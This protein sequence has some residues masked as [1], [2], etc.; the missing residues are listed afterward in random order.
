MFKKSFDLIQ[1][2]P[3]IQ[4]KPTQSI[5][6]TELKPTL[7]KFLAKKLNKKIDEFIKNYPFRI[8]IK[9]SNLKTQNIP[10]NM[11][12]FGNMG[13]NQKKF[14][15]SNVKI[16]FFSYNEN[17]LNLIDR[18]IAEFFLL[19]NFGAR[20]SKGFGSFTVK[21]KPIKFNKKVYS[22][23]VENWIEEVGYFYKLL[24]SGINEY[25]NKKHLLYAKPLIFEFAC[26]NN[27]SWEK[28]EIKKEFIKLGILKKENGLECGT[29]H[30]IIKDL[31]GLSTNEMWRSYKFKEHNIKIIKDDG[32]NK[33]DINKIE[34]YPSP[35]LFKP[36]KVGDKMKIYFFKRDIESLNSNFYFKI[37]EEY[38]EGRNKVSKILKTFRLNTAHLDIDDFLD[39]VSKIDNFAFKYKANDKRAN[40]INT[41]IKNIFNTLKVENV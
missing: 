11:L 28:R 3:I 23:E 36:I 30:K 37:L 26:N 18:Y 6:E 7:N 10:Q 27:I 14:V 2:T 20:K 41:I 12:Y 8:I 22:F 29:N 19:H 33:K 1:H 17:V 24:R 32:K 25:G 9:D 21:D 38:K 16:T 5:R 39:F 15:Y 4:F 13:G 40:E 34:R 31:L 35:I